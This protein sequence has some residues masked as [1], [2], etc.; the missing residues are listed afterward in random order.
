MATVIAETPMRLFVLSRV[1]FNSLITLSPTVA[2]RIMTEMGARL[3]RTYDGVASPAAR[4]DVELL[5][6]STREPP[7]VITRGGDSGW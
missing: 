5:G 1:E 7:G 2:M 3:R 4:C 6:R